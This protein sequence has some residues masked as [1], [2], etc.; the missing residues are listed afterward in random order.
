MAEKSL[1]ELC[2]DALAKFELSGSDDDYDAYIEAYKKLAASWQ[3]N[4]YP[5]ED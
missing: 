3:Q 1:G 5:H 4:Q 2:N